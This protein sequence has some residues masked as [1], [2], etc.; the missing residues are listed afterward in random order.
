[1]R[2]VQIISLANEAIV[3]SADIL[4]HADNIKLS[5]HLTTRLNRELM[6]LRGTLKKRLFGFRQL[7]NFCCV[8]TFTRH[9]GIRERTLQQKTCKTEKSVKFLVSSF[10]QYYCCIVWDLYSTRQP[11]VLRISVL[12]VLEVG[13]VVLQTAINEY[14]FVFNSPILSCLDSSFYQT[15]SGQLSGIGRKVVKYQ[16]GKKQINSVENK[17]NHTHR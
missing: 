3:H 2:G 13:I 6:Q 10:A 14:F 15:I 17:R 9:F 11:D 4:L 1:M 16:E 7:V 5:I 12:Q 8:I